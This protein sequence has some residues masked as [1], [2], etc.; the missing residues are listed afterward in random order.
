M[1]LEEQ[2]RETVA[3]I[4]QR[5]SGVTPGVG[6]ILGSG[7]GAFADSLSDK[8]AIPYTELPHF[9]SSSVVGHAGRLVIGKL[10]DQVVVAM[11]GRVHY[12]EGYSAAQ[13]AF[14]ARVLC[15]LGIQGLVVTNAAGGINPNFGPGDLMAITDHINMANC[16]PLMG[17]NIDSLGPRFPDMSTAY[18]PMLR[19]RLL[20]AA[21]KTQVPL[22]AGVYAMCTGPSY[23]TPAEVR[24]LRTIGAD[25]VGM[26]TVPEVIAASH[27]G[28]AVAGISCI[29]NLAAGIG[30]KPLSHEEVGEV[31][32]LAREKFSRLLTEF[33][34]T[35]RRG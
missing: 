21:K 22:R 28:V 29:T 24:M 27:M 1:R 26:S 15:L 34:P 16:N 14:P 6:I 7:L 2:L 11:Q 4:R 13:V 23:E 8:I 32:N 17:A 5:A 31:A 19:E 10:K 12:Y 18:H 9:P 20:E 3:A 33:L 25:A 30:D 35:V